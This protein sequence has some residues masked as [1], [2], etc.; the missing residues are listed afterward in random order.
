MAA[1]PHVRGALKDGG[2]EAERAACEEP[3]ELST[4]HDVGPWT[5]ARTAHEVRTLAIRARL[6]VGSGI[7][8]EVTGGFDGTSE[9]KPLAS[10]IHPLYTMCPPPQIE[11]VMLFAALAWEWTGYDAAHRSRPFRHAHANCYQRSAVLQNREQSRAGS[12]LWSQA[13]RRHY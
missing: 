7:A 10:D 13:K 1:L 3:D 5:V 12:Q 8:A 6:G 9:I 4:H 11:P 2:A